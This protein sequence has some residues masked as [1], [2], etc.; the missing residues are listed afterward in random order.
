MDTKAIGSLLGYVAG[1]IILPSNIFQIVKIIRE[2]DA[3]GLS[4]IYLFL[5][6]IVCCLY[7]TSGFLV[8]VEYIQSIFLI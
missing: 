3:S 7:T 8:N 1:S 2:K 5:F 4:I 6:F